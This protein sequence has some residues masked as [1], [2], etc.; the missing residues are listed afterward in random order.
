LQDYE[1]G[2]ELMRLPCMHAFHSKCVAPWLHKAGT[3]PVCQIDVCQA[4]A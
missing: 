4:M 2:D 1:A 3:C